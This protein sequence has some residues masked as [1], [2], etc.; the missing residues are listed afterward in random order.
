M[1]D[2]VVHR[3]EL[4]ATLI[5]VIDLLINRK[6]NTIEEMGGEN[7]TIPAAPDLAE[8]PAVETAKVVSTND[9]D[10]GMKRAAE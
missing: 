5:R 8:L 3:R 2:M 10:D 6:K 9:N 4:R 1:V 7:L